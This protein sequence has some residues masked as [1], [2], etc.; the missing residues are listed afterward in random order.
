M[1]VQGALLLLLTGLLHAA[2]TPRIPS[3]VK[4][5]K[6]TDPQLSACIVDSV[7]RLKP[8]LLKGIPEFRIPPYDPL[9]IPQVELAEVD[10]DNLR[11]EIDLDLPKLRLLAEYK[12]NGRILLE[13]TWF[14]AADVHAVVTLTGVANKRKGLT[15]ASLK[16]R[17][18]QLEVGGVKLHFENLFNGNKQ[19]GV[20]TNRFFNE[21]W[22]D[23]MVELR[24]VLEDT[25]AELIH[26]MVRPVFDLFPLEHLLP[27]D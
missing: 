11:V 17:Q 23:L 7:N 15:Y 8:Q 9:K 3:Y 1:L 26:S 16:E 13:V 19:L 6:R 24:P 5:C 2:K 27:Q 25:I 22:R 18:V 12:I 21:N 4:L 10:L 20:A 14:F